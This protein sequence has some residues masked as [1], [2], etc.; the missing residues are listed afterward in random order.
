MSIPTSHLVLPSGAEL[1]NLRYDPL[2][3]CYAA[4]AFFPPSAGMFRGHFPGDAIAP[5]YCLLELILGVLMASGQVCMFKTI[6]LA[7]FHLPVCPGDR[8]DVDIQL[9]P[10]ETNGFACVAAVRRG[11]QL[12]LEF[13]GLLAASQNG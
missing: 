5:G 8:L 2:A 7:K 12:V 11:D 1:S 10:G 6:E 3:G 13:S 9:L 4:A